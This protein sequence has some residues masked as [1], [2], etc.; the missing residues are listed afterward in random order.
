MSPAAT[1]LKPNVICHPPQLNAD[2]PKRP[3]NPTSAQKPGTGHRHALCQFHLEAAAMPPCSP[4]GP[5]A[6]VETFQ[7]QLRPDETM[8]ADRRTLA[9]DAA[10]HDR[11]DASLAGGVGLDGS[12]RDIGDG[13]LE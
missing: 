5:R 4:A 9:V 10:G 1:P 7:R 6:T 2:L 13:R 8:H 11:I 3:A 12:G